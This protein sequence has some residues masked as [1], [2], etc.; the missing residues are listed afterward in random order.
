[1][2]AP[3]DPQARRRT[4]DVLPDSVGK[5]D[6]EVLPDDPRKGRPAEQRET[7]DSLPDREGD[8]RL[9]DG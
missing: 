1:M 3:R 4:S 6:R 2:S 8:A 9:T 7:P 5:Q